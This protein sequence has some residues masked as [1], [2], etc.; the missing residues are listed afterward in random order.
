MMK[1]VLA[2]RLAGTA[3]A[4]PAFAHTSIGDTTG[5]FHGFLHPIGG[6]DHVLAMVAVGLFAALLGGRALWFVPLSFVK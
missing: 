5:F 1:R 4:S 3:V 2:L 6:I